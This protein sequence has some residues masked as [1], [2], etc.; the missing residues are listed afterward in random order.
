MQTQCKSFAFFDLNANPVYVNPSTD[1]IVS[2][3]GASYGTISIAYLVTN[4]PQFFIDYDANN[5]P[6]LCTINYAGASSGEFLDA[7][8]HQY[9]CQTSDFIGGRPIII[10]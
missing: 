3:D 1:F 2:N 5:N 9:T 6:Y 8:N 7:Q 10:R 4:N